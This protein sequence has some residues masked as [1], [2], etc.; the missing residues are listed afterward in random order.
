MDKLTYI[1]PLIIAFLGLILLAL[2]IKPAFEGEMDFRTEKAEA[3][4]RVPNAPD[5]IQVGT[6]ADLLLR[7]PDG[8]LFDGDIFWL[9]SGPRDTVGYHSRKPG[10]RFN[11]LGNYTLSAYHRQRELISHDVIVVEGREVRMHVG[12]A[13]LKAGE[14]FKA[15]DRSNFSSASRKWQ[16][17]DSRDRLLVEQEDVEDFAWKAPS[18]GEFVVALIY[19]DDQGEEVGR[20]NMP[21]EVAPPPAPVRR[22]APKAT[23]PKP[24][25]PKVSVLSVAASALPFNYRG[26]DV[27]P[28]KDY[29]SKQ[30]Y[31]ADFVAKQDLQLNHIIAYLKAGEYEIRVSRNGEEVF[32]DNVRLNSDRAWEFGFSRLGRIERD[33]QLQISLHTAEGKVFTRR[34]KASD[35]SNPYFSIEFEGAEQWMF[36]ADLNVS[37]NE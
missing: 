36:N 24:K 10:V 7:V 26:Q 15:S 33:D 3:I 16:V 12:S 4:T 20:K 17:R 6:A 29:K 9:I 14:E 35:V 37:G 1:P 27:D 13:E 11:Q 19:L 18:A 5:S 31:K 34:P 2:N 25:T 23:A 22:A 28:D 30:V 21:I 8:E 32:R